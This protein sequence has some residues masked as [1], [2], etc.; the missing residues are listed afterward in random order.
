MTD[1]SMHAGAHTQT[2]NRSRCE[3]HRRRAAGANAAPP[4][5]PAGAGRRA[6]RASSTRPAPW[7]GSRRG[8]RRCA[9]RRCGECGVEVVRWAQVGSMACLTF[10]IAWLTD[11]PTRA[12]PPAR[13]PAYTLRTGCPPGTGGPTERSPSTRAS[14]PSAAAAAP[15]PARSPSPPAAGRGCCRWWRARPCRG[16]RRRRRPWPTAAW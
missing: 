15:P 8:G 6:V 5:R 7:T 9:R 4:A 10:R 2:Q 11:G 16:R 14:A 1:P 13:M 3:T 12:L